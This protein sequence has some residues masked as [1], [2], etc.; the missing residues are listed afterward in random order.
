MDIRPESELRPRV[1][2]ATE[3][4]T[5]LL[6][7]L[8]PGAE[9]EHIGATAVPGSLT[10]GDLDLMVRVPAELYDEALAALD[11]AFER[12]HP[13]EWTPSL[14]SFNERPE[15]ELP[16][17]IQ[18]VAAG[19]VADRAFAEWRGR[20]RSDPGLL[21]RYNDFKTRH[22][23]DDYEAYTQAKGELIE[24]VL[25]PSGAALRTATPGDHRDI[26][27]LWTQAFFESPNGGRDGPYK[28]ADAEA[29][30]AG[31]ELFVIEEGI[32]LAAVVGLLRGNCAAAAIAGHGEVEI[33]RLAVARKFQRRGHARRLLEHCH[34][35]ARE[36]GV[37]IVLWSRPEQTA[38]HSLYRSLGYE[39]RPGRDRSNEG[40]EQIVFG[41]RLG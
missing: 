9:V 35:L 1:G 17:G 38:G 21:G 14:A 37:D 29:S 19:S 15:A 41:L 25:W 33:S 24:A 5:A 28:T 12:N 10:K 32:E 36:R 3:R 27:A 23:G 11:G 26:A 30:A 8:L 4:L 13:E 18:L 31:G 6:G 16:A 34:S 22:A 39:R 2:A 40:G 20:L 7:V